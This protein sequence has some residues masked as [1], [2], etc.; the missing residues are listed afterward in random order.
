[1][2][3]LLLLPLLLS[4]CVDE[5]PVPTAVLYGGDGKG[6]S[7][8]EAK[9]FFESYVSGKASRS[10][11][12]EEHDNGF[13]ISRLMLPVGEFVPGWEEG[14]S[15]DAPSLYSVD[16]PVQSDFSFRVLRVDKG[17][18]KVYQTKCWH[19]LV[20]VKDPE[21]GNMGCF[22]AFFIPD[23]AYA[24]SH[25]GDIGRVLTNGEEM[26]DYSGVKI[27]TALD[28]RRVRVNRYE[29]GK[30]VEGIYIDGASDREDYIFRMLHSEKI[31]GRVWLQRSRPRTPV[32]RGEDDW[33]DDFWD[34]WWYGTFDDD[35][36]SD[37]SWSDDSNN[38]SDNPLDTNNDNF[39][40]VGNDGWDY[41]VYYN[42]DDDTYYIDIDGDGFVDSAYVNDGYDESDSGDDWSSGD[43]TTTPPDPDPLPDPG[44]A[45]TDSGEGELGGGSGEVEQGGDGDN[46][47]SQSPPPVPFNEA[48]QKKVNSLLSILEK[49]HGINP[50][51]YTIMKSNNCNVIAKIEKS[52]IIVLCNEFFNKP[53]LS[54]IDRLATIWHEMYHF[55]HKHYGKEHEATP[56][57]KVGM[58]PVNLIDRVPPAIKAFLEEKANNELGGTGITSDMI[59][60]SWQNELLIYKHLSIEY[61]QNEVE[62][63]RAERIE[64]PDSEVSEYYKNYR[65]YLE[66]KSSAILDELKK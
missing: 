10:V 23:R 58:E 61:N 66:W 25:G 47:Q 54:D 4:G 1:M 18:G 48:E 3:P 33:V 20:V 38:D 56:F 24:L 49:N 29:N 50:S 30:K 60:S 8:E 7:V 45:P 63:Y 27:Y 15:T 6:L 32:S 62:T 57:D 19:K 53:E 28:G 41:D 59:E 5:F 37:D 13:Y 52:G 43:E 11:E 22:I 51:K 34:D 31:L 40:Q 39:V 14:F 21:S 35:S 44:D 46:Q 17:S 9:T 42:S 55:D 2:M 64:F 12:P 26:G 65:D 36:W 16:V